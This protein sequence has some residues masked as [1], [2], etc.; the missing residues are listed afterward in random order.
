MGDIY[1]YGYRIIIKLEWHENYTNQPSYHSL[2]RQKD[3]RILEQDNKDTLT[4][5]DAP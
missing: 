5:I 1:G 2:V 4:T 3:A